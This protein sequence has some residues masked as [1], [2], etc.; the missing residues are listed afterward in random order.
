MNITQHHTSLLEISVLAQQ[1]SQTLIRYINNEIQQAKTHS[2]SFARFMEMA[3][4]EPQL[5]YYTSDRNKLGEKGDFITAPELSPLFAHCLGRQWQQLS[6]DLGG[7][8]ILEIGAGT[9]QLAADLLLFLEQANSLPRRYLIFEI[10]PDLKQRQ[11][12]RLQSRIPHLFSLIEWLEVL[13]VEP[14]QGMILA[15][16][17]VDALPV[18][19]FVWEDGDIQEM[20][21]VAC[22][23]KDSGK[24]GAPFGWEKRPLCSASLRE[25]LRQLQAEHFPQSTRYVSELA[26]YADTWL[27]SVNKVLGQGLIL[28]ID[29]GY[30]AAEYYHVDRCDGTLMCYHQHRGHANPFVLVGLQDITASVNFSSLAY[31]ALRVDLNVAGFTSQAAFLLN[32]GLL[33]EAEKC[34]NRL[35]AVD[36]NRQ[37]HYLLSH[38]EMGELVKVMGLTRGYTNKLC[39]FI[40]YDKKVRL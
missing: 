2:I 30:T 13:P 11:Q 33:Q 28:I 8:D 26:L 27:A 14:L 3:L 34:Y 19:R 15:N 38:N 16:E 10:S 9:G 23:Q 31:S 22:A 40:S 21:V 24:P 29:Y 35:S 36:V 4:Y 39:G 12:L 25:N 37:L 6:M 32:N 5:G 7:G 18:H 1:R 20:Q 17:V